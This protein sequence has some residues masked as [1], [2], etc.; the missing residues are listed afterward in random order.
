MKSLDTLLN[1]TIKITEKAALLIDDLRKNFDFSKIEYKGKNDLV[2]FVDKQAELFLV[3][4]LGKIFPEAGFIAEEGTGV[5]KK[6]NWVIDPLDGTTNFMHGLPPYSISIGLMDGEELILG[7]ILEITSRT[8]YYAH[9]EGKAYCDGEVIRVSNV[10]NFSDGLYITGYP[11]RDFSKLKNFN[12]L[13]YHF[14]ANSH[15]LR[16]FGSAAVDLAY[17]AC[18]KSEGFFEFF[19]NPWDV[20][21]GALIVQRAGGIVTDFKGGNNFIY[22]KELIAAASVHPEMQKIIEACWYE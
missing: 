19:L 8:C 18:G 3:E 16:R 6:I 9:K 10:R 11:Y 20:A 1:Q 7:V 4:S 14:L 17:V 15:G 2:S 21:A 5:P 13:M 12:Q 22:G